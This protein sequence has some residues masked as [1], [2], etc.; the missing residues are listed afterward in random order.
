MN[1]RPPAAITAAGAAVMDMLL[2]DDEFVGAVAA[3]AIE[4]QVNAGILMRTSDL[5]AMPLEMVPTGTTAGLRALLAE[6]RDAIGK[7]PA[8]VK[9]I[10]AALEGHDVAPPAAADAPAPDANAPADAPEPAPTPVEDDRP[11]RPRQMPEG[12][13]VCTGSDAQPGCGAEIDEAQRRLS[14]TRCRAELCRKCQAEWK[15]VAA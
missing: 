7:K 13:G 15:G 10:N 3:A 1:T 9:R 11:R 14:W 2:A 8:L 4:R 5:R 12:P 6:A